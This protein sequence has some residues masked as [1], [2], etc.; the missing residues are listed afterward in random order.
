MAGRGTGRA[1]GGGRWL[2]TGHRRDSR[3]GRSR[4]RAGG[5]LGD[6]EG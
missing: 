1:R 2:L 3:P 4:A 5:W 6:G